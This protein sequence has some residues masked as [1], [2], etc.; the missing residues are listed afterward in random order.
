MRLVLAICGRRL[1]PRPFSSRCRRQLRLPEGQHLRE[2]QGLRELAQ[3]D[4]HCFRCRSQSD[5]RCR[6]TRERSARMPA[7]S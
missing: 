2:D 6:P 4:S 1:S 3:S 7:P 5:F